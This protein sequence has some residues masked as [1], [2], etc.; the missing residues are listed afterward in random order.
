MMHALTK[1]V[2]V[3][4]GVITIRQWVWTGPPR[5]MV[6]STPHNTMSTTAPTGGHQAALGSVVHDTRRWLQTAPVHR[7]KAKVLGPER[8]W[9]NRCSTDQAQ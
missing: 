6:G 2:S 8:G 3:M 7:S 1:V 9:R 5:T 4:I